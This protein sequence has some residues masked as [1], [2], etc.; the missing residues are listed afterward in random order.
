MK[1]QGFNIEA[2]PM[3]DNRPLKNLACATLIAAVQ[4]QQM[5]HDRDRQANRPMSDAF[6]PEI[7]Q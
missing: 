1:T 7:S 2:V 3:R 4:V 5:L 6:A